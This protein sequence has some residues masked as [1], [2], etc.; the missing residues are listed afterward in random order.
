[1][2][3]TKEK[4]MELKSS[5]RESPDKHGKVCTFRHRHRHIYIYIY[6]EREREPVASIGREK[7]ILMSRET[8]AIEHTFIC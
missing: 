4:A 5:L 3:K 2:K 6:R 1:M 8:R 7:G